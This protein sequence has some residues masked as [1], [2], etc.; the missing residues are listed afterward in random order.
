MKAFRSEMLSALQS[1]IPLAPR[2]F[3]ELARDLGCEESDL[4]GCAADALDSGKARRFGA[5]FDARRLGFKS[6]L[7]CAGV[8][9][10]DAAASFLVPRREVS[11]C[12]LREAEGC[13]NLWWTWSAP[14]D[15]FE[16]SVAEIPFPFISLPA[17]KRYKV[18]VVFGGPTRQRDESTE[19]DLPPPDEIGRRIIRAMQGDTE[20]RPDYFS[21]LAEKIGIREWNLL[22]TLEMWRRSGR[23]KRIGLLLDH[24]KSGYTANGMCCFRIEESTQEAGRALASLDEVSHCYERPACAEFPYNL[25]AMIHCSSMDEAN[26]GFC[27]LKRRLEGLAS[28]PTASVM[29]ISTKEYKKTS[30]SFFD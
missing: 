13:P 16:S 14:S 7:C 23:L 26:A 21:H 6:T 5:V 22:S 2:P 9:D 25:F 10:P 29:L 1:G 3:E 24:R 12:Y 20:L 4:I 8:S 11:H 28:T 17:T 18:D 19:D 27:A 15:C 30:L